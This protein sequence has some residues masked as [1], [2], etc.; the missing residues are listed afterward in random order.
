MTMILLG[1]TYYICVK[2]SKNNNLI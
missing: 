1:T 2:T